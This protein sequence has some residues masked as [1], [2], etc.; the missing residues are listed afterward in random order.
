MGYHLAVLERLSTSCGSA[1]W[2]AAAERDAVL[3]VSGYA[4]RGEVRKIEDE[5]GEMRQV[6]RVTKNCDALLRTFAWKFGQYALSGQPLL[7]LTSSAIR[8]SE[9]NALEFGFKRY[10]G[11]LGRGRPR[12]SRSAAGLSGNGGW[13]LG[14]VSGPL[15]PSSV[16]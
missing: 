2:S 15:E 3:K 11:R 10:W 13:W 14:G 5:D 12:A 9:R 16:R 6:P 7:G 8:P 1:L 4:K